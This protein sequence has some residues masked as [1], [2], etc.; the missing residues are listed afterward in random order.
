M[1]WLIT[2]HRC[3]EKLV[4]Q[5]P[6]TKGEFAKPVPVAPWRLYGVAYLSLWRVPAAELGALT[7]DSGLPLFTL[8]GS[9]FVTTLWAEYTGGTLSYN[10]LAT[11]VLVR[12]KGL[13]APA[14]SVT[15]IWVDDAVSAEG[16]R[17]LWCIPKTLGHFE[18]SGDANRCFASELTL[19]DQSIAQLRFETKTALPGRPNLSGFVIQPSSGGPLRTR[20]A[21]SGKLFTGQADWDFACAGALAVLS[22]RK[23][24]MSLCINDMEAMF[25][26]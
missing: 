12:G 6:E 19:D 17:R 1:V 25:G 26:L 18:T 24:L 11:A 5:K 3:A 16:G 2:R 7:P 23:P 15:A 13:L 9:A 20:C 10:E 8:A 21:V 14:A 22:G 4:Q